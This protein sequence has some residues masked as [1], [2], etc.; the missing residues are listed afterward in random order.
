MTTPAS[1]IVVLNTKTSSLRFRSISHSPNEQQWDREESTL[2]D[3][4]TPKFRRGGAPAGEL[5]YTTAL[6]E[7]LSINCKIKIHGALAPCL[8]N[9]W[10]ER[11]I[12]R[13]PQGTY[14]D[15]GHLGSMPTGRT[16]V[17]PMELATCEKT[18][19][20]FDP[21]SRRVPTTM[22]RIAA[23]M[24]AYSAMSCPSSEEKSMNVWRIADFLY[25]TV[26]L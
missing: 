25:L 18:V 5:N 9:F 19:L 22:I 20:E 17:Q 1:K 23:T 15:H 4:Q 11:H 12:K 7:E 2:K 14:L 24:T 13:L 6:G 21:I 10:P 26:S 8:M 16:S 3:R